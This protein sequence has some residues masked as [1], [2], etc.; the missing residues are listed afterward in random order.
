[1]N[2]DV[3]AVGANWAAVDSSGTR[4]NRHRAARGR[5]TGFLALGEGHA[6]NLG[7]REQQLDAMDFLGNDHRGCCT[8]APAPLTQISLITS[9][10]QSHKIYRKPVSD[11][12]KAQHCQKDNH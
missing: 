1:M 9:F 11:G 4:N 3:I 8:V 6:L 7:T 10:Y 12:L 5:A 2:T